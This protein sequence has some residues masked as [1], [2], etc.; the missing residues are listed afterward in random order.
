MCFYDSL[1]FNDVDMPWMEK[2]ILMKL[3]AGIA[4]KGEIKKKSELKKPPGWEVKRFQDDQ[5]EFSCLNSSCSN[6]NKSQPW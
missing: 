4:E 3:Q 1:I 6:F 5:N 2:L